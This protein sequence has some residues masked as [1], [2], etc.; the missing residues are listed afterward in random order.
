M[1]AAA[2]SATRNFSSPRTRYAQLQQQGSHAARSVQ[3]D[4]SSARR[5][6]SFS[7]VEMATERLQ[8]T[9]CIHRTPLLESI[10]LNQAVG[11]RVLVK[12]EALQVAGSFKIR[13][14][15]NALL[16]LSP[17]ARAR[18]VVAFSS[19]NFGQG[20]AAACMMQKV[21]CT[22]VMPGD[23]PESKEERAKSYGAVVVRSEIVKDVNREVTAAE[24]AAQISHRE[25]STL[26]HPFDYFDVMA[27]Q[28]SCGVEIFEQCAEKQVDA[29]DALLVPTGGG[30]L[31]AGC[32]TAMAKLM[33]TTAVYAVEPTGY[34]DHVQSFERGAI[35]PLSESP[36]SICDSL[37]AVA[38]GQL[39]FP[40]NAKRLTGALSVSDDEVKTAMRVAFDTLQIVLEP[41]GAAGLA[42]VLSRKIDIIGKTVC[43]IASGGNINI[44]K[45]AK[46]LGCQANL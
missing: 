36:D 26:L 7:D 33:P 11:G 21:K 6:L 42:A 44:R 15:M 30:G 23:A 46:V 4:T 40:V 38:P 19:G 29:L 31:A 43:V 10:A 14:A 1:R 24:L 35:T 5:M 16:R 2:A 9:N 37:Q 3:T 17:E 41:G 20:L 45:F 27:G 18:G 39:T 8:A 28:G 34:D 13:G 22:I 12:A 32:S 25:G